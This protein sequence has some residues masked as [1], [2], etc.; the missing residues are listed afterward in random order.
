[1]NAKKIIFC[2]L[3]CH[4]VPSPKVFKEYVALLQKRYKK[5]IKRFYFRSKTPFGWGNEREFVEFENGEAVITTKYNQLD[6]YM[7]VYRHEM[8]RQSCFDCPFCN[9]NRVGDISLADFWGGEKN[10]QI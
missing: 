10:I 9:F 3:V 4:G 7:L 8:I 5:K 2:D 6:Y 1:M